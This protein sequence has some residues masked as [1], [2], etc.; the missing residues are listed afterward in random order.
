MSKLKYSAKYSAKLRRFNELR[1][2]AVRGLTDEER[3]EMDALA[4]E[5]EEMEL[6][7]STSNAGA[8]GGAL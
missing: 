7:A 8:L 5:L 3:A 2:L 4:L 6:A 1:V